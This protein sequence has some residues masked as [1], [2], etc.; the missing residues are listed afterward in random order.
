MPSKPMKIG[1]AAAQ[2]GV[3]ARTL[4]YYE[5]L[6]LIE[7]IK[8]GA[9]RAYTPFHVTLVQHI[10]QLRQLGFS[11]EEIRQIMA[12]KRVLLGPEG[13]AREPHGRLPL[14][15]AQVRAL[16]EKTARLKAAIAE[17]QGLLQ[18]LEAFLQ[19]SVAR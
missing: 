1:E 10:A 19:R 14:P 7:A 5:E 12:L 9:Q 3:T 2:A 15:R 6:G 18:R 4:R 11:L 8:H 17:Q 13:E 16:Q